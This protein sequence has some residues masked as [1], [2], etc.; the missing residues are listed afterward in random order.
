MCKELE[1]PVEECELSMGMSGDFELAVS[2]LTKPGSLIH[3]KLLHLARSEPSFTLPITC[4][5]LR[6]AYYCYLDFRLRW[7]VRT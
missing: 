2:P 5:W 4:P 1:I 3:L 6:L 7:E